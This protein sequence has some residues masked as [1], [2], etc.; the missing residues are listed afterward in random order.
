L[1]EQASFFDQIG[2]RE[3][4][5]KLVNIFYNYMDQLPEAI[6]IRRQHQEDLAEARWKLTLFLTGWLVGPQEYTARFGHPRLRARHLPFPIGINERDQWLLCMFKAIA[7]VAEIQEPVR[8]A[9]QKSLA[10]LADH[11]R[12]QPE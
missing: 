7:D 2:G 10:H 12:N 1:E 6:T 5:E 4:V 9:L 11:M 8:S 3:T